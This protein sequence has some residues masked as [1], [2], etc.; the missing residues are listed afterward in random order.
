MAEIIKTLLDSRKI[1]WHLQGVADV[2]APW[3]AVGDAYGEAWIAGGPNGISLSATYCDHVLVEY[4]LW[5][6]EPPASTGMKVS[7]EAST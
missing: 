6:G 5:D 7:P 3:S 2:E 1:A 4:E